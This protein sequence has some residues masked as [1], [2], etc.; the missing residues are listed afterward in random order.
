MIKLTFCVKRLAYIS[1]RDFVEE[2][3]GKWIAQF[4]AL[5]VIAQGAR[6]LVASYTSRVQDLGLPA[7]KYDALI[8]L[9]L[10]DLDS[11]A[12]VLV[13]KQFEAAA[14]RAYKALIDK[15]GSAALLTRELPPSIDHDIAAK[16]G[17]KPKYRFTTMLMRNSALSFSEF[18]CHHKERHIPLF[19]SIPI[20]QR[21]VLRYLVS[22]RVNALNPEGFCGKYD[23]IVDFW[24]DNV[25]DLAAIFVNPRYLSIVRPDER[26]FLDLR[27]CDFIISRELPPF[28]WTN[29]AGTQR[30]L[31]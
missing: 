17:Q 15:N 31:G 4:T 2:L 24:F 16:C 19:S 18:L 7:R 13:D 25:V 12:A 5:P 8:E 6:Q 26:R 11:A 28:I 27:A 9:W 23:G 30:R 14:D 1:F 21:K 22:H 20:I 3:G 10:D 29:G